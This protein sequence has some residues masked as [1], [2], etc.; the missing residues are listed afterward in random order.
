MPNITRVIVSSDLETVYVRFDENVIPYSPNPALNGFDVYVN[1]AGGSVPL[2][3]STDP[4]MYYGPMPVFSIGNTLTWTYNAGFGQII[5]SI[6]QFVNGVPT[7]QPV[8]GIASFS[9][10]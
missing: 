10:N 7:Q 9:F 2:T 5:N 3:A 6:G 1:G 8:N 4:K